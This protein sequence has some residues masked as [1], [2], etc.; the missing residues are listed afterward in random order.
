MNLKKL[1][2]D[3][4][5]IG[6]RLRQEVMNLLLARHPPTGDFA[7]RSPLPGLPDPAPVIER[8]RGT[9]FA[10]QVV[11]IASE[12]L[13]HR[14]PLL[15]L[16]VETGA[17]IAWRRDYRRNI[18]T[19]PDYFR[20]IPYLDVTR[21]GDHKIIWELNRH[22]HWVL[23]AQAYR[24]TG[25]REYLTEIVNQWESWVAANPFQHGIN[26]CSALEVAFRALSWTWTHHLV[27]EHL[28]AGF[29]VEL[30]RHGRHL[31]YNLSY[32]FSP[33]THLLG[34]A[35][36]LHALGQLFP[37]FPRS[38][39]WRELGHQVVTK[40]LQ[41]QVR[42]DGAHF[43]QSTYYHVYAFDFF[44]L[45]YL[46]AGRPP[47]Y[48]PV[49]VKM[50]EYLDAVLG[51]AR[52][53]PLI[54][55][56]DG[57]RLFHP[58]GVHVEYGRA[59]MSLAGLM[60]DRADWVGPADTLAPLAAWWLGVASSAAGK[61]G[62]PGSQVFADSGIVTLEHGDRFIVFDAGG[63]GPY[64]AGHSHSDTLSL[65]VRQGAEELL[66]DPG[67]FEY[68]GAD[69]DLFR[70][71]GAHATVR[72]DGLN[73]AD[74]AGS[75]AWIHQP[76]VQITRREL[77]SACDSMEALCRYRGFSHRRQVIFEKPDRLLVI[78]DV[79]GPPG[80]HLLEQFWPV[81]ARVERLDAAAFRL[82][83]RAILWF[84]GAGKLAEEAG[85]RSLAYGQQEAT[86]VIVARRLGTL[87][88]RMVAGLNFRGTDWED[89]R[90]SWAV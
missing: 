12:V 70:G 32:Y 88:C 47:A 76:E 40:E 87:P 52:S 13:A 59:T 86:A 42:G 5:E 20:R 36:A 49:L 34:E 24:L 82:G 23:L 1:L 79:D 26:W 54:G 6:F 90:A 7:A 25:R 37:T 80:E 69:R 30:A 4:R 50:G 65:Y 62:A 18:E 10:A 9:D 45:H 57:G 53:L 75:F 3:P 67:T 19:P 8:L 71:S 33:N 58:Y 16:V 15:G 17:A 35:V 66:I 68:V 2:R 38:A 74:S 29:L 43:E 83:E 44:L 63:F 81:G 51:P 11:A 77:S 27:G 55:D 31:E 28:P 21:V 78:D 39:R 73:Q 41:R 22:Q 64:G 56:D 46:L 48:A 85:R 14:F 61:R 84:G 60:L 72:I 89:D